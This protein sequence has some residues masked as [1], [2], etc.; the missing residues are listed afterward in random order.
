[1]I[2][3]ENKPVIICPFFFRTFNSIFL[4]VFFVDSSLATS[5]NLSISGNKFNSMTFL[6]IISFLNN[7]N[8]R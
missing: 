5:E 6:P 3:P 1:M 7:L 4:I 2:S 8:F